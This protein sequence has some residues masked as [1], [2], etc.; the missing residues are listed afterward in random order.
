MIRTIKKLLGSVREYKKPS[1]LAPLFVSLEVV[2]EV[3]IPTLTATLIDKG[4]NA[5]DMSVI[6]KMGLL[7]VACCLVSLTGGVL[8]GRYAAE[9]MAGFSKNLRHD[10]FH[11]VQTF[12][13][14]NID[15]FS[16]SS[17]VTR[18][19]T[20]VMHVQNT[21]QMIIRIAVR[22]PLMLIFSLVMAFTINVK[23][24]L[25]F[26]ATVPVLAG[27]LLL[28]SSH[29]HPIF[30]R[31]FKTM[32]G[33]NRVVQEN[34]HGIRV[35]KSFVRQD[36]EFDKFRATSDTVYR[37]NSKAER[38]IALN[39]PLMM[40]CMNFCVL[41]VSW[42][43]AKLIINAHGAAGSLTTGYLT[44]L[45]AYAGQILMGL[46]MLSM[47]YV[48]ITISRAAAER[49][50]ELLDEESDIVNPENPVMQV[51]DGSVDFENVAF[52]Y[53]KDPAK[54]CLEG[55]NLHINSGETVGI[56]GG[57][58]S[59]KTSLMQ[60]IPRL[61][62]TTLGTVKVGGVDV[63][64]YDITALRDSVSMVLQKNELFA[65]TIYQN[66]RWGNE[67]AT[68]EEV[69][70]AAQLAQADGFIRSFPEG[71][72]TFIEQ[73]GTNVSGGQKQRLCI[74]RA[75]LKKPKILILD[76]STSAVDTRTDSLIR[77]AFLDEIPDTTKF[78]IAQRVA[79]VE[80]ADRIIVLDNGRVNGFG[81]HQEL[82][83]TNTIYQEVYESQKKGAAE[84]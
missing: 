30:E 75:L 58:G 10:M 24:S 82:L 79:S 42:L 80:E 28:I 36:H 47:I 64:D 2:M 23:L 43:G 1:L 83:A 32:D 17:I 49:I 81:T 53:S 67:N 25:I 60:L 84:E 14:A 29:V 20:D 57:T 13:F 8:S 48:M 50:T 37:L 39:S 35:V 70:H 15:K 3:I 19:T 46:N 45:I 31:M 21:Y 27:G 41:L 66:L 4:I 16:A 69:E 44:S 59:S 38:L 56:L 18:M 78:I 9:A 34:L 22:A 5:G 77:K 51:K 72:N 71:Y 33:M 63:K 40:F 62:D 52:S 73:G 6:L 12:S 61:Y 26:L 74:A 55:I 68:D 76:D 65:G 7:L 11:R 54:C